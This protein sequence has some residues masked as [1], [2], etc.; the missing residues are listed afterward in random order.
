MSIEVCRF[1]HCHLPSVA[2]NMEETRVRHGLNL[3]E[4]TWRI[5]PLLL[6]RTPTLLGTNTSQKRE[7]AEPWGTHLST[8]ISSRPVMLA[9]CRNRDD[10]S[11]KRL[12]VADDPY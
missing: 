7:I 10:V 6:D 1:G 3:G 4:R 8:M 12:K 5:G 2:K 11:D 9:T